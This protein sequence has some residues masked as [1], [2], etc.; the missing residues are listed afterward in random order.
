[1][2]HKT[3]L[4]AQY[5]VVPCSVTDVL[6][7][8]SA[9][10]TLIPG[11]PGRLIFPF[12]AIGF[13]DAG[14]AFTIGG[15]AFMQFRWANTAFTAAIN[16]LSVGFL[17]QTVPSTAFNAPTLSFAFGVDSDPASAVGKSLVSGTAGN[18]DY[19]GVGSPITLVFFYRL[20]PGRLDL[21]SQLTTLRY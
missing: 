4:D 20:L 21:I 17:D 10:K 8:H 14:P 15:A 1:V 2:K 3:Y 13:R 7:F 12:I 5:K 19:T 16:L 9:R 11:V 6:T 18:S